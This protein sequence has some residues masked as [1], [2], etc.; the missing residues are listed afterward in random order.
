MVHR[1]GLG[2]REASWL[3]SSGEVLHGDQ[4]YPVDG[5][6]PRYRAIRRGQFV[7]SSLSTIATTLASRVAIKCPV[8]D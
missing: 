2:T 4:R 5:L 7:T 1:N 8:F 3:E 6:V